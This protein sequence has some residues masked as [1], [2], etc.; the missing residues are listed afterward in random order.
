[1]AEGAES[2][3]SAGPAAP[4]SPDQSV[5]TSDGSA[6]GGN[7]R[8]PWF[9]ALMSSVVGVPTIGVIA[10]W[11]A[12]VLTLNST[13]SSC[14]PFLEPPPCKASEDAVVQAAVSGDLAAVRERLDAGDPVDGSDP[15][16][17]SLECAIEYVRSDVALELIGRGAA[18][19]PEDLELAASS[20]QVAVVESLLD[21]GI[22]T[23]DDALVSLTG[24]GDYCSLDLNFFSRIPPAQD[25]E[26]SEGEVA[27]VAALLLDHG[28]NPLGREGQST[29]LLWATFSEQATLA[30]VLLD[31]GAPPDLGGP[32]DRLSLQGAAAEA[33]GEDCL[34]GAF[35]PVTGYEALRT[36]GT[37]ATSSPPSE[38][39]R[40]RPLLP[41]FPVEYAPVEGVDNVTPLTAAALKGNLELAT[42][43]LDRGADPNAVSG[44]LVSPL[45]CA[46]VRGNDAM[47]LLLMA[48][49]ASPYPP[50][51]PR[52]M[53]PSEV[54]DRA[55]HP[56][57]ARLIDRLGAGAIPSS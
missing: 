45:Y 40:G 21:H 28:A 35:Y 37:V 26:P 56:R 3:S 13:T 8:R 9:V 51:D 1:M 22:P 54:A 42:L 57:T 11:V 4:E 23:S 19:L 50:A 14:G 2:E 20:G 29:P 47:L 18:A 52:V 38:E 48:R 39:D 6:G 55:G 33:Q 12:L 43:L 5:G 44:G 30:E 36:V 24:A 46:A 32:V 49:G 41:L 15:E 7:R 25:R 31:R 16:V 10:I 27:L 34:G 53:S 17:R